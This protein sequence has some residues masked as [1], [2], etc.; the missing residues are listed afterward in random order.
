VIRILQRWA[1]VPR[2][3]VYLLLFCL[4]IPFALRAQLST[5][6]HLADPGFWPTK[7]DLPR[8][9]YVG[10]AACASCHPTIFAAQPKTSMARTA[11]FA[12]RDTLLH[13]HAKLNFAVGPYRYEIS[14]QGAEPTYSITSPDKTLVATLQWA[15]GTGR[16]GQ[17]YL[18]RAP[19]KS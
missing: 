14:S 18:F 4:A 15:F 9:E 10:P 13:A 2:A 16:V 8:N 6:D 11:Q 12:D 7:P 19:D 3:P 1:A 5:P 17:S